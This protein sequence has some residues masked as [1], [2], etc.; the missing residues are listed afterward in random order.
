MNRIFGFFSRRPVVTL[1]VICIFVRAVPAALIYGTPDVFGWHRVAE[2]MRAGRNPYATGYLNWP[3]LR[4]A[5]IAGMDFLSRT[6]HLPLYFLIKL[7]ATVA[8]VGI[9]LLLFFWFKGRTLASKPLRYGLCYAL[10]P[11]SIYTTGIH[12]NFDAIP[13]FFSVAAVMGVAALDADESASA[14]FPLRSAIAIACGILAKTWPGILLPA[15]LRKVRFPLLFIAI[16]LGPAALAVAVLYHFAPGPTLHNLIEYRGGAPGWWGLSVPPMLLSEHAA[17]QLTQSIRLV[18]YAATLAA[19][20]L[21][22]RR[23]NPFSGACLMLVTFYVFSP[24]FG[25]QYLLWILPFALIADEK[26][27]R[28]FTVLATLTVAFEIFFR[29]FNGHPFGYPVFWRYAGP[30]DPRR[31]RI[32]TYLDRLPLWFFFVGWWV[33]IFPAMLKATTTPIPEKRFLA[34]VR[35]E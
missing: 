6:F 16:A 5:I 3:P 10:N 4:P 14:N 15:M 18:F 9:S 2:E 27:F 35:P 32:I 12:G 11:I 34:D 24:G 31:D 26:D 13:L 28:L 20:I 19:A 17:R 7:P 8:D 25:L 23:A 33:R 21:T 1:V 22:W 29:P 30:F